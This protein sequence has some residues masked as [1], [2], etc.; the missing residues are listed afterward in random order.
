MDPIVESQLKS[1][2]AQLGELNDFLLEVSTDMVDGGFTEHPM[3]VAHQEQAKI[4]EM[5][6]DRDEFGF[7][8]S[9]N[10]TT[11][12]RFLELGILQKERLGAFLKAYGNPKSKCCVF[13]MVAPEP[14]FIFH[15]FKNG[16]TA[17]GTSSAAA[18]Q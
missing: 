10:A 9:I 12:E 1:L 17:V 5:I 2:E 7:P 8:F 18:A 13:L 16:G 11:L 3:Y 14:Q 4:G 6:V 15:N